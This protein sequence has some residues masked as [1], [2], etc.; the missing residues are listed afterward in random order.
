MKNRHKATAI[1]GSFTLIELL[2]VIAIIAI[3][4]SI[5]LPA[6]NKA[7]NKGKA[8]KCSNNFKQIG[9]SSLMYSDNYDGWIVP[10]KVNGKYWYQQLAAKTPTTTSE[11]GLKWPENFTCPLE[12]CPV[13]QEGEV[14]KYQYTHYGTNTY[15]TGLYN[16]DGTLGFAN[17][18]GHKI[19]KVR[20]PSRAITNCDSGI[21]TNYRMI[22]KAW[23]GFRHPNGSTNV[24]YADGH[25]QAAKYNEIQDSPS[26]FKI[27]FDYPGYE[28]Y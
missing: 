22:Y 15:L 1:K 17:E 13:G 16:S 10:G 11:S 5:L 3:L 21:Q 19:H 18:R 2:V 25:V 26:S 7:R 27:G 9:V 28:S 14:G 23:V 6:L 4:A 24:L 8:I 20:K 12:A